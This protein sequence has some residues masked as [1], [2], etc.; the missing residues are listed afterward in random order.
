MAWSPL[1]RL[2]DHWLPQLL[3]CPPKWTGYEYMTT[4]HRLFYMDP[5]AQTH[6][7]VLVWQALRQQSNLPILL[8]QCIV[9]QTECLWLFLPI[10][11]SF[12]LL[13]FS[14]LKGQSRGPG[15]TVP[16]TAVLFYFL[17]IWS[18]LVKF[19]VGSTTL[20]FTVSSSSSSLV[21]MCHMNVHMHCVCHV[22]VCVCVHTRACKRTFTYMYATAHMS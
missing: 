1:I 10:L 18:C 4:P 16:S 14:I 22:C 6:I 19:K 12:V 9:S 21:C 17:L 11:Q 20:K 13:I 5:G 7:P 2:S 8:P 3:L 15:L